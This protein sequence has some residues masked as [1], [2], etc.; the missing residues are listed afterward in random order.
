M[1]MAVPTA[2]KTARLHSISSDSQKVVS[3]IVGPVGEE[4]EGVLVG[5]FVG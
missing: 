5:A 4:V 2:P 1:P 3:T